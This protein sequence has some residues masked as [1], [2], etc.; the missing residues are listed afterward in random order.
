MVIDESA[1]GRSYDLA[2]GETLSVRLKENP[3]TG[4]CWTVEQ[5]SGLQWNDRGSSTGA[6][7]ATAAHEFEFL[8]TQAGTHQISLRHWREWEGERGVIARMQ[9]TVHAG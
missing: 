9:F 1:A 6:P 3:S 4:Y 7:G 2:V 5:A 8:A